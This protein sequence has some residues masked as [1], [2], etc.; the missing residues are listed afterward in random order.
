[1][2]DIQLLGKV[3]FILERLMPAKYLTGIID[4]IYFFFF[5]VVL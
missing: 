1:M 3:D 2:E 4:F 5:W